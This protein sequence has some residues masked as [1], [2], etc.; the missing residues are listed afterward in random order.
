[1]GCGC[2]SGAN[3]YRRAGGARKAPSPLQTP[4]PPPIIAPAKYV[5]GRYVVPTKSTPPEIPSAGQ[6]EN[7]VDE[8][9]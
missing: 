8:E 6:P 5:N 2:C 3:K 9:K 1:M 7:K 4:K